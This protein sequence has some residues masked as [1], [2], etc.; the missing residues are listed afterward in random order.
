[1]PA[2]QWFH[3]DCAGFSVVHKLILFGRHTSQLFKKLLMLV[4]FLKPQFLTCK[5]EITQTQ[6]FFFF[7]D[8]VV[9]HL[10][11]CWH[12]IGIKCFFSSSSSFSHYVL[13][14]KHPLF[15]KHNLVHP[16][17]PP[18]PQHLKLLS[19][20]WIHPPFCSWCLTGH[21][22]ILPL[23]P[24]RFLSL[25]TF[26]LNWNFKWLAQ[27]SFV[28]PSQEE[29]NFRIHQGTWIIQQLRAILSKLQCLPKHFRN[30]RLT[31]WFQRQC[32][33]WTC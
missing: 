16:P 22:A 11:M 2:L 19:R 3:T 30:P 21:L 14:K 7:E 25:T 33:Q 24:A 28:N 5:R 15:W 31:V 20:F 32:L 17:T 10:N 23:L 1:M 8:Q 6:F 9:L 13:K 26:L 29:V 4:H 12:K 27:V 18:H